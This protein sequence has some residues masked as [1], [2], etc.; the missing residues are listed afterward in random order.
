MRTPFL[1]GRICAMQTAVQR[2]DRCKDTARNAALKGRLG[3]DVI[4]DW[5][6]VA[7]GV[8]EERTTAGGVRG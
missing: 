2:W 4:E 6:D 1:D 7:E 8:E 3:Y 5:I